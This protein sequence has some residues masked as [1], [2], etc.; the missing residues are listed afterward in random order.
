MNPKTDLKLVFSLIV[1]GLVWGTTYLGIR[2][3]VETIPPWYITSI[4]QGIAALLVLSL[5][6]YLGEFQRKQ[7]QVLNP[8]FRQ[9][10]SSL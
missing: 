10:Q 4:R 6:L 8:S 3:A 7:A 2:V 9:T 1:V 5:L